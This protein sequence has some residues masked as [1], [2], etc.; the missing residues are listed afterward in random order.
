[1][2]S[3]RT[4]AGVPRSVYLFLLA[5]VAATSMA[6]IF[7]RLA[8]L[9]GAPS[10]LIA[11]GRLTLSALLITP[12]VL[13]RHRGALA[14]L[15]RT[16][17]LL[18]LASGAFLALHFVLWITSLELTSVLIS[19]V[20][21]TSG[22]LWVAL[23]EVIFLRA[24]LSRLAIFGLILATLGGVLIGVFGGGEA[25]P[26]PQPL[27]GAL[28]ALGGAITVAAYLVIGRKLRARIALLPYIW[29]VY[30]IA[31]LLLIALA[32]LTG[33]SASG[34]PG[35]AWVWIALT[36]L[37]PQLIGHTSFNYALRYMSATYVSI[38]AQLEP[39]LSAVAAMVIFRQI[40]T[41]LQGIGSALILSGVVTA[42]AAQEQAARTPDE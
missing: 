23:M 13:C 16:D 25:Q 39:I 27:L 17:L 9:D 10:M 6:A 21:V 12:I 24:R 32:L 1:M 40:P 7:I 42:S 38:A 11:V 20:F 22:P 5:G 34:L 26:G 35:S 28:M 37:L 3:V 8:Q 36:A 33:T 31:A 19:V 15:T 30:G 18:A 2:N 4:S 14:S 41:L 29:L